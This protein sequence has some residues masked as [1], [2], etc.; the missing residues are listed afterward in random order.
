M[1]VNPSNGQPVA[2]D[3]VALIGLMIARLGFVITILIGLAMMFDLTMSRGAR[4]AHMTTG[5]LVLVGTL[6]A[7]VRYSK[8]GA[9]RQQLLASA[10]LVV[11]GMGLGLS[12]MGGYIF[13]GVNYV[14]PLVM[15]ASTACLEIGAAKAKRA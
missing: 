8:K 3:K 10:V 4:D 5:L 15:L 12:L 7:V 2:K 9:G 13:P 6:L 14:H 1:Q 11:V